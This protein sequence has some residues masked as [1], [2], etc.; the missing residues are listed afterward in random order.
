MAATW[1]AVIFA[2]TGVVAQDSPNANTATGTSAVSAA[3]A[4]AATYNGSS[5]YKPGKVFDR[6]VEIWLEFWDTTNVLL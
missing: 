1:I 5:K 2:A 3:Q 4:T 6:F